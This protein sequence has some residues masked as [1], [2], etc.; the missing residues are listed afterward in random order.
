M[1][2]REAGKILTRLQAE[3]D[4]KRNARTKATLGAA[5]EAWLRVHEIEETTRQAYEGYIR[6][7]IA[8]ALGHIEVGKVTAQV[9]EEFYADLRRCRSRRH[10]S[11]TGT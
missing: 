8:P 10:R 7:H 2:E 11:P 3:V 5:L 6:L 9:L 4:E 1:D